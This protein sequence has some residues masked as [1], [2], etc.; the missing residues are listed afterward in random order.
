[1]SNM[2]MQ[3]IESIVGH[4][5]A[6]ILMGV[7]LCAGIAFADAPATQPAGDQSPQ[8]FAAALTNDRVAA[9]NVDRA[10]A[11]ID[12][13][14]SSD[15]DAADAKV[16]AANAII[17]CKLELAARAKWGKDGETA[18]AHALGDIMPDDIAQADW[19]VD[20]DRAV[21]QFKPDGLSPLVLIKKDG[22]WKIDLPGARKLAG[23]TVDSDLKVEQEASPMLDQLTHD[24]AD[25]D[26]YPTA[27]AFAQHVKDE[28]AKLGQ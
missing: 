25:K 9:M 21:A 19:A 28:V 24:V 20:R 15:K 10:L 6:A 3:R 4:L 17:T 8:K 18:V 1:M 26:A 27:D 23:D 13:D 22:Q 14:P 7:V 12:Y 11:L 5:P 16:T 2:T